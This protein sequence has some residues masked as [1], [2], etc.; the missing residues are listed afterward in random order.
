[1]MRVSS[2]S[3]LIDYYNLNFNL[4]KFFIFF[5]GAFLLILALLLKHIP[6]LL[7][8]SCRGFKVKPKCSMDE[9]PVPFYVAVA[10]PFAC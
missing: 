4:P 2:G 8:F 1:M 3:A 6:W 9:A 5:I 10:Y 7:G